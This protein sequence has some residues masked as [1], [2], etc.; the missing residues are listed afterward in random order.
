MK[1]NG[2]NLLNFQAKMFQN[3]QIFFYDTYKEPF[4]RAWIAKVINLD[5]RI[6][7]GGVGA[8]SNTRP[9]SGMHVCR[10]TQLLLLRR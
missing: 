6:G 2:T 4:L 5:T 3:H 8:G 9:H 7:G 10:R 1:K